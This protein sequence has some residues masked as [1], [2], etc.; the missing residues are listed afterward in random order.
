MTENDRNFPENFAADTYK[1]YD[2]QP[3]DDEFFNPSPSHSS[4]QYTS[5]PK[6]YNN[7]NIY[8]K[9]HQ[10]PTDLSRLSIHEYKLRANPEITIRINIGWLSDKG[11]KMSVKCDNKED[12]KQHYSTLR[13]RLSPL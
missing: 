6:V 13:A 12:I 2:Y 5:T 11:K 8:P 4:T 3:D 9:H 7:N 1:S 10:S